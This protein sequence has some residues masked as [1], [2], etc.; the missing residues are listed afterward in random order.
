MDAVERGERDAP[1]GAHKVQLG[2]AR[3]PVVEGDHD[4]PR[5]VRERRVDEQLFRRCEELRLDAVRGRAEREEGLGEQED[6]LFSG[7]QGWNG[8]SH[9]IKGKE[10]KGKVRGKDGIGRNVIVLRTSTAIRR[11]GQ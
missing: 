1:A 4:D 7:V 9:Q 8:I 6:E 3:L 11:L 10:R 2:R 5:Y